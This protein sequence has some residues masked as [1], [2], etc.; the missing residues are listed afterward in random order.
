VNRRSSRL[1]H[2]LFKSSG[3]PEPEWPASLQGSADGGPSVVREGV[4]E[5]GGVVVIL[6]ASGPW[7]WPR[8]SMEMRTV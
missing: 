8:G 6:G 4:G 3:V 1:P 7:G 2:V 5:V